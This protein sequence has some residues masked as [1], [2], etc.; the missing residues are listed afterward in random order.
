MH[1][2]RLSARQILLLG[3][4]RLRLFFCSRCI[5]ASKHV[6]DM[7]RL[8]LSRALVEL[9][10]VRQLNR[11]CSI[12]ELGSSIS[13]HVLELRVVELTAALTSISNTARAHT[14]FH[15]TAAAATL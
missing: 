9:L 15:R 11:A 2:D 6:L 5:I 10:L 4:A 1:T 7:L 12:E 8:V 13:G 14:L 3:T